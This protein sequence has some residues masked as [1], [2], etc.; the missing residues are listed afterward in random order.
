MDHMAPLPKDPLMVEANHT[1]AEWQRKTKEVEKKKQQKMLARER[2]E[3]TDSDDDDDNEEEDDE[4]AAN[5]EWDD[6]VSEDT[7][8][9]THSSMQGHFRFHAEGSESVRPAKVG[10][11]IGPSSGMVGAGGSTATPEVL[12][13][14][15][16]MGGGRSTAAPK[17]LME[18][19]GSA[20]TPHEPMRAGG[21][22]ATPEVSTERGGSAATP[23][24]IRETSPAAREQGAGSKRSCPDE[25]RQETRGS[26]PKRPYR[27][28]TP[29]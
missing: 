15:R 18:G 16:W 7:L 28:T 13:E 20:A 24:K 21:S 5:I 12:A 1:A 11:I 10:Q 3:E 23:S 27:P 19:G 29:K 14:D 25:S 8:T 6:P 26:S 22:A 4:V 2:K 9:G 17:V